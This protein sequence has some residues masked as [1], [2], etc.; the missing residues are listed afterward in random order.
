M[1]Q[2][3]GHEKLIVYLGRIL[4]M[5]LTAA[6]LA[7]LFHQVGVSDI[8]TVMAG[9][10]PAYWI[11]SIGLTLFLGLMLAWRWK[12]I[13]ASAGFRISVMDS[14][15]TILGV[16]PLSALSPSKSGDFLRAVALR[17]R[18]APTVVVGSVLTERFFDLFSLALWALIG[19]LFLEQVPAALISGLIVLGF[20]A[21]ILVIDLDLRIPFFSRF[22]LKLQDLLC[23]LRQVK[24]SLYFLTLVLFISTAKWLLTFVLIYVLFAAIG[25]DIP[26]AFVLASMPV[27]IVI[28][29]L[30]ITL[31]GMGIREGAM[32]VLFADHATSEQILSAGLLYTLLGYGLFSFLGA[33]FTR[34]VLAG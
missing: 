27:A 4:V 25:S 14:L 30:P 1:T 11:A 16:W 5:V 15:V 3:F 20:I 12:L 28:G 29:L 8:A 21:L 7:L 19:S 18:I 24:K 23:T 26:L 34:R 13:L 33:F 2:P 22:A 6:I 17:K 32:M 9:I 10:S 31:G